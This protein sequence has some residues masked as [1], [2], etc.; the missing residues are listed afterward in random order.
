MTI[1]YAYRDLDGDFLGFVRL[2]LDMDSES[3]ESI[4]E[5][6]V[7][8]SNAYK[9]MTEIGGTG[10]LLLRASCPNIIPPDTVNFAR[11]LQLV[12]EQ[13]LL[14]Q[15]RRVT[16]TA[17]KERQVREMTSELLR[18]WKT[19]WNGFEVEHV[20]CFAYFI[21][22]RISNALRESVVMRQIV[23]HPV[24]CRVRSD[25]LLYECGCTVPA[26]II[27]LEEKEGGYRVF[28]ALHAPTKVS[29]SA[30]EMGCLRL[31]DIIKEDKPPDVPG[32]LSLRMRAMMCL[33]Q[34][35]LG[36]RAFGVYLRNDYE[37][38]EEGVFGTSECV[39]V[40]NLTKKLKK[41][42]IAARELKTGRPK[43]AIDSIVR[44]VNL[45]LIDEKWLMRRVRNKFP[46]RLLWNM[47]EEV[48]Y[49]LRMLGDL[50]GDMSDGNSGF[51]LRGSVDDSGKIP[52][53]M[54]KWRKSVILLAK[55]VF[56]P[57]VVKG[58]HS[59]RKLYLA[60]AYDQFASK[61]VKETAFANVVFG[62]S[63]YTTTLHYTTIL[64]GP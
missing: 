60:L 62:H 50:E 18:L 59:L 56:G 37:M 15:S 39:L 29:K 45:R 40:K 8:E 19:I 57:T 2:L 6:I 25:K 28:R 30:I 47:I 24:E 7:Q 38:A 13:W 51:Y 52:N 35:V 17:H 41:I 20:N 16:P 14:D 49:N 32:R 43:L 5:E 36:S 22:V 46:F 12:Y 61:Q 34:L 4:Q 21:R 64:L 10:L 42:T 63:G 23:P 53:L 9:M 54:N 27:R 31:L 58:T 48:R 3:L 26:D 55:D 11:G 1:T 33:L 44:P